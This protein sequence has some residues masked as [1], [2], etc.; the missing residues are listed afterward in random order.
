MPTRSPTGRE[1][2]TLDTLQDYTVRRITTNSGYAAWPPV[3]VRSPCVHLVFLV[4]AGGSPYDLKAQGDPRTYT[5]LIQPAS[6][7]A[8]DKD[9][10][11]LGVDKAGSSLARPTAP[12]AFLAR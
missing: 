7:K 1:V 4:S 9:F 12:S 10:D 8:L 2:S 6:L 5:D 11:G 3:S